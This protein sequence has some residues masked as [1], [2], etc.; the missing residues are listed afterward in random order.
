MKK[1]TFRDLLPSEIDLR[2]GST[3]KENPQ[4]KNS[5]V[6]GF[7]LLLYKN[8]RVDTAIL[9]ETFGTLGWKNHY[10]QV[11]NTMICSISIYDEDKKEWINKDN[12]GDDDFN[13]EQVKGELSDAF[14]RSSF[15]L[16]IGKK[17]YEAP[18][19]WINVDKDNT[20]TSRYSVKEI[21]YDEKSITKLV[22]IN[23]KTKQIVFS[24]GNNEKVPTKAQE[25]PK[26]TKDTDKGVA[27]TKNEDKKIIDDYI[28]SLTMEQ[29]KKFE[30]YLNKRFFKTNI[31]ELTKDEYHA[32]AV[33]IRQ[34]K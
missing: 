30:D 18:F 21:G 12:G 31:A 32:L 6:I 4:D 5:K 29:Y 19:I 11:K 9:D 7:Q 8:Q 1:I 10:Y 26:T 34:S 33:S 20:P 3:K 22:I 28:N 2:V 13:T 23:D 25:T 24:F 27:D 17:L 15:N 16:G 14:K